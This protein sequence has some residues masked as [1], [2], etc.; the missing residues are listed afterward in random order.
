MY[1][2]FQVV[3]PERVAGN[4][5]L[6]GVVSLLLIGVVVPIAYTTLVKKRPLAEVGITTRYWLPSIILGAILG[7]VTYVGVNGH[8]LLRA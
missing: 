4:F 1:V 8:E 2:A 6:F 3:T 5:L 7:G